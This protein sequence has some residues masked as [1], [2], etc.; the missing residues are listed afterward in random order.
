VQGYPESREKSA[1][2]NYHYLY[3]VLMN[4]R[5]LERKLSAELKS[6]NYWKLDL[7]EKRIVDFQ[8]DGGELARVLNADLEL[9]QLLLNNGL[10]KLVIRPDREHQCVRIIHMPGQWSDIAIG[11]V[12]IKV[13]REV[14]P[15]SEAFKAYNRIAEDIRSISAL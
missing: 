11:S 15:D 14:L 7:N 9:K 1:A 5:R 12:K 3:A 2:S 6:P 8:W 13:G 4:I 10:D